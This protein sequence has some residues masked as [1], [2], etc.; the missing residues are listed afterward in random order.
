MQRK[1][2]LLIFV[3][4]A[5]VSYGQVEL[6]AEVEDKDLKVNETFKVNFILQI[7]GNEYVQ[8]SRLKLPDLSKFNLIGSASTQNT[9]VNPRTN[10]LVNQIVYQLV[11]EPKKAG[12]IKVGSALVQINGKMLKTEPIDVFVSETYK[13]PSLP[14]KDFAVLN[15]L[16]LNLEVKDKEVF[17]NQ[18]TLAILRAYSK[19]YDGYRQINTPVFPKQENVQF[20]MVSSKRQDIEQVDRSDYTS[21]VI[22]VFLIYPTESGFV[23]VEPITTELKHHDVKLLS[24]KIHLKVNKLPENSPEGFS[25]AVGNFTFSVTADTLRAEVNKPLH[26]AVKIK[27]Q[28]NLNNIELPKI[29]EKDN[30]KVF[31]PKIDKQ[32]QVTK[33]GIEGEAIA[34]YIIIPTKPGDLALQTEQFAFF[35]PTTKSY[36]ATGAKMLSIVA[37]TPEQIANAKTTLDKVN[38]ISKNIIET[39]NT[40]IIPSMKVETSKAESKK[41]NWKIIAVNIILLTGLALLINYLK[42]RRKKNKSAKPKTTTQPIETIS[43]AEEKLRAKQTYSV[44]DSLHYLKTLKEKGDYKAFFECYEALKNETGIQSITNINYNT[45]TQSKLTISQEQLQEIKTIDEKVA[46]LKYSPMMS[47]EEIDQVYQRIYNI[48]SSIAK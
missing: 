21:Q 17:P 43:E 10:E 47:T 4:S 35:N 6:I 40:P 1:I 36:T 13:K 48:F 33:H 2:Y 22:G 25:N 42:S 12:K 28:G 29:I 18:P 44:A 20:A 11:L 8:E 7:N 24:N 38:D 23:D 19:N 37:L 26:V 46:E 27:G 9:Y 16:Y 31:P 45:K 3:L 30:Y 32:I 15:N 41:F 14:N 39:V 34:N 5:L